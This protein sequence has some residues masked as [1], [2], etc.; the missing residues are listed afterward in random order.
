MP[1]ISVRSL[2]NL[3]MFYH[4]PEKIGLKSISDFEELKSFGLSTEK[5]FHQ[6]SKSSLTTV[7][8]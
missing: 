7:N 5:L 6:M 4:K 3:F 8:E 1:S 2:T